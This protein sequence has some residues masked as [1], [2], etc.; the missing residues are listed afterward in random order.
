M[1]SGN[2]FRSYGN[3]NWEFDEHG[4]MR[5]R[6]AAINDLPIEA[7]E[8][9]FRWALGHPGLSE[10]GLRAGLS[11]RVDTADALPR[12]RCRAQGRS[13]T[14]KPLQLQKARLPG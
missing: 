8:R 12:R 7:S 14:F 5:L 13:A 3:E 6:F 4:V 9:K 10:P 11:I 1:T 2:W